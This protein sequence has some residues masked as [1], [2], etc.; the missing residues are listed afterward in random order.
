MAKEN[1]EKR[2]LDFA[3]NPVQTLSLNDLRMTHAENYPDGTP[4]GG[5]YHYALLEN[6]LEMLEK[7]NIKYEIG[8]IFAANN[9]YKRSPG[10]TKIIGMEEKYG[11]GSLQSHILRRV[12]C[13]LN[14][15]TDANTEEHGYNIAVAWTQLG[16]QV[17]F[18][19]FTYACHNQTI[20]CAERIVSN[21]TLRGNERMDN[22]DRQIPNMLDV[23][24]SKIFSLSEYAHVD[25]YDLNALNNYHW[26]KENSL[27][28]IG[29]LVEE[30][31]RCTSPNPM[32]RV[33]RIPPLSSAEI[34]ALCEHLLTPNGMVEGTAYHIYQ[35][36]TNYLKPRNTPFEN[37]SMQSL[38]IYNLL[39]K[40]LHD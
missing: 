17:G 24:K 18:G 21:Y 34:N 19:P 28:F 32:I 23:I 14:L 11:V 29:L 15:Q 37:I 35:A 33:N 40:Y 20:C 8:E 2:L 4:V 3:A 31:C 13:N 25:I 38:A 16:I 30:R 27:E 1:E 7:A 36:C 6:I 12:F 5:I 10:V 22:F 39:M 9:K 26:S